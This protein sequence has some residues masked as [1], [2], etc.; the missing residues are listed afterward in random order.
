MIYLD[1]SATTRPYEEVIQTLTKVSKEYFGNPSSIH[2]LGSEAERLLTQSRKLCATLL[3]VNTNEI[4]FT[5]GGTEGNNIAIKGI[6]LRHQQRGKHIITSSVEH[7][8]IYETFQQLESLGFEVTYLPVNESGRVSVESVKGA[9]RNDTILVSL[10]HVN[11]EMGTV[12]PIE[13]IG[14]LLSDFPKVF[15]HVD[16]V[17]GICKVPLQLENIDLCTISG[18]KFHG[19]RGTGILFIREGVLLSPLISG[20][21][22][23]LKVRAG[24]ENTPGI[25]ATTKALRLTLEKSKDGI[26]K[27]EKLKQELINELS[28][29]TGVVMNTPQENAAPHILNF[30]VLDIKPEVLIHTLE[31]HDIYISS[32]SACSSKLAQTSRIL[33]AAGLGEK[34]ASSAVRVSLSFENTMEEIQIFVEVMKKVVP[35]LQK[36]MG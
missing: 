8:S 16:H 19:V 21:S 22:Q 28:K 1:N 4:V 33:L 32:Q 31:E 29:L 7:A 27:L 35:K 36:V 5:S 15:F 14:H 11:N 2:R 18:H 24:T 6:A 17:Q 30:S 9:L 10:I 13:Q 25:A 23:E 34:R 3:Q 26:T 20:G 12:Q